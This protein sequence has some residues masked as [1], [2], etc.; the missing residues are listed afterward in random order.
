[1]Q[2]HSSSMTTCLLFFQ[3]TDGFKNKHSNRMCHFF[4]AHHKAPKINICDLCVVG[5]ES[6][7]QKSILTL[8]ISYTSVGQSQD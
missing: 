7:R 2:L 1:M 4:T 5:G 3:V 8:L 6:E